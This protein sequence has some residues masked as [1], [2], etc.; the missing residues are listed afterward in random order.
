MEEQK[1]ILSSKESFKKEKH[2]VYSKQI[3]ADDVR[4]LRDFYYR[5]YS[6]NIYVNGETEFGFEKIEQSQAEFARSKLNS[7]VDQS[8]VYPLAAYVKEFYAKGYSG[9]SF[10]I[11]NNYGSDFQKFFDKI[12]NCLPAKLIP[13]SYFDRVAFS[14]KEFQELEQN[15]EGLDA[16]I[17][18]LILNKSQEYIQ[19]LEDQLNDISLTKQ[20]AK[21]EMLLIQQTLIDDE[22]VG[23][24]YTNGAQHGRQHF[25]AFIITSKDIIKPVSWYTEDRL[26]LD[27]IGYASIPKNL[28]KAVSPQ[29][30]QMAC[31][32]LGMSYMK[33]LLKNNAQQLY[34]NT[35]T[36]SYFDEKGNKLRYFLPSPQVLRYSQ[37]SRYNQAIYDL[38]FTD[39]ET[40]TLP[41]KEGRSSYTFQT[42]LGAL[43]R[44]IRDYSDQ[45][46][47]EEIQQNQY[48]YENLNMFRENWIIAYEQQMQAR[49]SM[50]VE[51]YGEAKNVYLS[52]KSHTAISD[53]HR[54]YE[55][56]IESGIRSSNEISSISDKGTN[57]CNSQKIEQQ[58]RKTT[59]DPEG[60]NKFRQELIDRLNAYKNTT[61][62]SYAI[63]YRF[64]PN[65]LKTQKVLDKENRAQRL[66][67]ALEK[68]EF[69]PVEF[70]NTLYTELSN[71]LEQY[72]KQEGFSDLQTILSEEAGKLRIL[73]SSKLTTS[74]VPN[75]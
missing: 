50:I 4:E 48:F 32:T 58:E 41:S 67:D 45:L 52:Y 54:N 27:D 3:T 73:L 25:E 63:G 59:A 39:E 57:V 15:L 68:P 69:D 62:Y 56:I 34:E 23:Y 44:S 7:Y 12:Q 43:L 64:L 31:G 24:I 70:L 51:Q 75:F 5:K 30:D 2:A 6:I 21:D 28:E 37:S 11:S 33:E 9:S 13:K 72:S 8:N 22:V 17:K 40:I 49:E 18:Q 38:L 20:E 60:M 10:L 35:L 53:E 36:F 19:S 29:A 71:D 55:G 66:I 47:E 65:I 16:D 74:P 42:V 14:K 46:T 1:F 26:I 61:H